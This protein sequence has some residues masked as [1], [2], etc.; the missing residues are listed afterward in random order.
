MRTAIDIG[1]SGRSEDTHGDDAYGVAEA[2]PHRVERGMVEKAPPFA[3]KRWSTPERVRKKRRYATPKNAT[4]PTQPADDPSDRRRSRDVAKEH[5]R[6]AADDDRYHRPRDQLPH[7]PELTPRRINGLRVGD[8]R[9][10]SP[11]HRIRHAS[12]KSTL[13]SFTCVEYWAAIGDTATTNAAAQGEPTGQAPVARQEVDRHNP[14]E[15]SEE[16]EELGP[17]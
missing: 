6:P 13:Y 2:V 16:R 8:L 5:R 12:R 7:T 3:Q 9:A 1:V 14:A 11:R 10:A 15:S 4:I 17:Q